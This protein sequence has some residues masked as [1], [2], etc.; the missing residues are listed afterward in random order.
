MQ[1]NR[2]SSQMHPFFNS[3]SEAAAIIKGHRTDQKQRRPHWPLLRMQ[4]SANGPPG[5]TI[6]QRLQ[7]TRFPRQDLPDLDL[8]A[9][10]DGEF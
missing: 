10:T 4:N 1:I 7:L 8:E 6:I 5:P 3:V 9:R 2:A